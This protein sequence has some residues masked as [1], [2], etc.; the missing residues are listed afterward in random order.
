[1]DLGAVAIER[2]H[3][4]VVEHPADLF[5]LRRFEVVITENCDHR[6]LEH[7][8]LAQERARFVGEAV[9]GQIAAEHQDVGG[10]ADL[11]EKRLQRAGGGRAAVV[12]IAGWR[13]TDGSLGSRHSPAWAKEQDTYR[14]GGVLLRRT[15]E[16]VELLIERG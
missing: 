10:L 3:T 13:H 5:L 14:W 4:A 12:N 16:V 1:E 15:R 2:H 6:N 7:R 9:V 8:H 11:A